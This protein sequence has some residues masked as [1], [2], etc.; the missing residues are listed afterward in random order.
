M[1]NYTKPF[2]NLKSPKN[3]VRNCADNGKHEKNGFQK[4]VGGI[5]VE[6]PENETV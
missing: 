3:T 1:K 2:W 6:F 4:N 5:L